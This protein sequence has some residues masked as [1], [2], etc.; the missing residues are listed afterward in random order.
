MLM[1]SHPR[2]TNYRKF[3]MQGNQRK[4]PKPRVLVRTFEGVVDVQSDS[5]LDLTVVY[6]DLEL[7][8][9]DVPHVCSPQE[10]DR[11]LKL[12]HAYRSSSSN[13]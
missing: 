9:N 12:T 2:A 1:E 5:E 13:W 3:A 6:E 11:L 8:V 10:L 4:S 7:R